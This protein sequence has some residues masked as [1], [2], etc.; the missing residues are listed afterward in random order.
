MISQLGMNDDV[1]EG[2]DNQLLLI[3]CYRLVSMIFIL[4]ALK[5]YTLR[6]GLLSYPFYRGLTGNR[7]D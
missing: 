3:I 7:E 6:L 2:A 4:Y 5:L 1:V